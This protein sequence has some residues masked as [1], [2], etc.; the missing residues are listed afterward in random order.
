[1]G[2]GAATDVRGV[3]LAGLLSKGV[4]VGALGG[5]ALFGLGV[6]EGNDGSRRGMSSGETGWDAA[7]ASFWAAVMM[8]M[9]RG[10]SEKT[11]W[12]GP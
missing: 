8:A 3:T 2:V 9:S 5:T 11:C 10:G 4:C 7:P 12:S 1:M 6:S